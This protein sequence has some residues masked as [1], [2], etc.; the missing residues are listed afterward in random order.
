M[1]KIPPGEYFE[2]TWKCAD[3][4]TV[5]DFSRFDASSQQLF[6]AM[7]DE[8]HFNIKHEFGW[9]GEAG[10]EQFH[11]FLV[12]FIGGI[13]YVPVIECFTWQLFSSEAF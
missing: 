10:R 8:S 12:T 6:Y 13:S 7:K 4:Y 3:N 1:K 5:V 2:N 9:K 11:D